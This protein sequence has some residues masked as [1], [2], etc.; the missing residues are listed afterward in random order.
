MKRILVVEDDNSLS[1]LL[2][3]DHES[4]ARRLGRE[5]RRDRRR[6]VVAG[7]KVDSPI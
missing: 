4:S 2:A 5:Q 3:L 6:S 7:G 1:V